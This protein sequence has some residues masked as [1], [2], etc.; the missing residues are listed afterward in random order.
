MIL[1]DDKMNKS[2]FGVSPIPFTQQQIDFLKE[3]LVISLSETE[4]YSGGLG[5]CGNLYEKRISVKLI[6]CDE[7]ISEDCV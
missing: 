3:N 2:A 4:C 6:L 5:G 7:V 1:V